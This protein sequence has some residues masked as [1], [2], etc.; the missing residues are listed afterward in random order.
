MLFVKKESLVALEEKYLFEDIRSLIESTRGRVATAVN[1]AQVLLYWNVG[2]RIRRV[3]LKNQR[4]DYGQKIVATLSQQLTEDYGRGF[5]RFNLSR[6]ILFVETFSNEEIVATLSQQ[7]S[8]SHFVEIIAVKDPLARDFYAEMCRM[9]RWSVRILRQKIAGML[10][11]RTALSKK[12]EKLIK[13]ELMGLRDADKMTPDLVFRDPYFLD[14]LGLKGAY[15]EKDLEAAI[16]RELESF[17]MELGGGF[18]FVERQKRM[19]VD[20]D[21]FYL[22]LLF[23]HRGLRRLVAIELKMEKFKPDFKG[24]MELYMRWLDKY[25]RKPGEEHP[26]GLILCAGKS[27]ERIELLELGKSGIRVAEYMTKLLPKDV[28]EK[29][30]H[31]TIRNARQQIK[32]ASKDSFSV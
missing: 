20:G 14:F 30:F 11:E 6:M 17:I 8:W 21:D 2:E 16:L 5:S 31:E 18:T 27:D 4:A 9:E 22:D 26:L 23:Y 32:N 10:F 1:V 12:P 24:Q 7:L 28:L 3:V 13:A 29:K 15:Q 25:E 19:V